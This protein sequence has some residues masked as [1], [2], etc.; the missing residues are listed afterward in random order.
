M[1]KNPYLVQS[2]VAGDRKHSILEII[3]Q[4]NILESIIQKFYLLHP[5][6]MP[7]NKKYFLCGNEISLADAT[8]FPT[9]VFVNYILPKFFGYSEKT[10]FKP[11]IKRWF[12]FM[13][14]EVEAASEV[15]SEIESGL[16]S[17]NAAK[18]WDPIVAEYSK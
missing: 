16:D 14:S 10:I 4:Y 12:D 7:V 3:R 2:N 9:T 8:L 1:Y 18:R 6:F 17:W 13:S 5:R 11:N 15:R